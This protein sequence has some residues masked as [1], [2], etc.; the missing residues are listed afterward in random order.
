MMTIVDNAVIDVVIGKF[1]LTHDHIGILV[2]F[3]SPQPAYMLFF[4]DY[5]HGTQLYPMV[6]VAIKEYDWAHAV[7]L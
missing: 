1:K 4:T 2:P 3:L 5:T 7:F 6:S